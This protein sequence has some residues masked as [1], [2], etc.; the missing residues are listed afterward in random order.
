[1]LA[2]LLFYIWRFIGTSLHC[3]NTSRQGRHLIHLRDQHRPIHA[4]HALSA[5]VNLSRIRP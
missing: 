5:G 3:E 2:F 1:M 4:D